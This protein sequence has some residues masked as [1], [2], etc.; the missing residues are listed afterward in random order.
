MARPSSYVTAVLPTPLRALRV[1]MFIF[2]ALTLVTLVSAVA[3]DAF[4]ADSFSASLGAA[5][6]TALPGALTLACGLRLH[7]G[8]RPLFWGILALQVFLVLSA[9]AALGQGDPRGLGQLI[10]PVL[11]L[12]LVLLPSSRAHLRR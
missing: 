4:E 3:I 11:M 9:L 2:A 8:G 1:V 6:W 7:A 5:T 10:F 12:I